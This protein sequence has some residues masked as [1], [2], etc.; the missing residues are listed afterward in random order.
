MSA[1]KEHIG[2]LNSNKLAL[3]RKDLIDCLYAIQNSGDTIWMNESAVHESVFERLSQVF[4]TLQG[5][6]EELSQHFPHYD[7]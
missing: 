5:T 2:R 4:L 1:D 3:V 6:K 7:F